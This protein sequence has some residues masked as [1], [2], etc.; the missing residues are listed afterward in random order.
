MKHLPLILETHVSCV[1]YEQNGNSSNPPLAD[2]A[3]RSHD[4]EPHLLPSVTRQPGQ[5]PVGAGVDFM[6]QFWP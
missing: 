6:N 1:N 5:G 4:V 2:F 3:V